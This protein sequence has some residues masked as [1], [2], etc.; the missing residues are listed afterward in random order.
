MRRRVPVVRGTT[1]P[2][3]GPRRGRGARGMAEI[4]FALALT[5]ALLLIAFS[6]DLCRAYS[7][8]GIIQ[9]AARQGARYGMNHP[10][11]TTTIASR[12]VA[13]ATGSGVT[14]LTNQ[15]S[16]TTPSG[17]AATNPVTVTVTYPFT[18]M[19][20]GLLGLQSVSI[21][22]SCTMAIM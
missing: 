21:V 15:V 5:L 10:T 2:A 6:V 14:L 11:D 16:V 19:I 9:N 20:A 18:P 22:R 8:A 4:E 17:T 12:A 1:P 13:E 3:P 7:Q